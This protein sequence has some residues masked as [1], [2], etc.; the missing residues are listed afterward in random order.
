MRVNNKKIQK[1]QAS[2]FRNNFNEDYWRKGTNHEPY[3]LK[4]QTKD[5][6]KT[7]YLLKNRKK[8]NAR[9]IKTQIGR[10]K[11]APSP[12]LVHVRSRLK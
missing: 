9:T 2:R 8:R 10:R 1:A 12:H 5:V 7:T 6:T 4:L 11:E 3:N